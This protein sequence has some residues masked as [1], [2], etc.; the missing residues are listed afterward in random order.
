MKEHELLFHHHNGRRRSTNWIRG[1]KNEL[2]ILFYIT[3][4]YSK[5][6]QLPVSLFSELDNMPEKQQLSG[7][8]ENASNRVEVYSYIAS[9]HKHTQ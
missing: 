2:G 7:R 9:C 1:V 5:Q 8:V 6:V 4:L 3:L